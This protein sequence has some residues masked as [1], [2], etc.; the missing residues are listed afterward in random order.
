MGIA[1]VAVRIEV[2]AAGDGVAQ[3]RIRSRI[4]YGRKVHT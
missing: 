1:M 4:A 3:D 2:V